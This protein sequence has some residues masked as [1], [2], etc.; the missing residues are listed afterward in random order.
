M[1]RDMNK[2]TLVFYVFLEI[3]ILKDISSQYQ[4]S[5]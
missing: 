5:N 1:G 3:S 2:E 4:P